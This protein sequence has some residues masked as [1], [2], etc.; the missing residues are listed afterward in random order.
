MRHRLITVH[1]SV[2][3]GPARNCPQLLVHR[4]HPAV[5]TAM[6]VNRPDHDASVRSRA[7][8]PRS[9]RSELHTRLPPDPVSRS[10]HP[11]PMSAPLERKLMPHRKIHSNDLAIVGPEVGGYPASRM[12]LTMNE[13]KGVAREMARRCSEGV[14]QEE[15]TAHRGI[16]GA[17][18][19]HP[20]PCRLAAALLAGTSVWDQR[21]GRPVKIVV[22]QRRAR[23]R[24]PSRWP[25]SWPRIHL[26][27]LS[28]FPG[29]PQKST[30]TETDASSKNPLERL[31]GPDRR[32][33]G[34]P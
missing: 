20:P 6:F 9:P 31:L 22:G 4:R 2:R 16:Y 3:W 11:L 25:S 19:L 28:S 8:L 29:P 15:G 17:D 7:F 30:R 21:G 12:G 18:R 10:C 23:R 24:T 13:Q 5:Q 34:S 27:L 26:N 1:R 33:W 32:R 14:E